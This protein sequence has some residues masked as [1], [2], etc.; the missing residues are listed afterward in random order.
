MLEANNTLGLA[1]FSNCL[2]K[3][4]LGTLLKSSSAFSRTPSMPLAGSVRYNSAPKAR[5][6][7]LLSRLYEAGMTRISL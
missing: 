3:K 7:I 6:T 1:G 2:K 5:D 4:L